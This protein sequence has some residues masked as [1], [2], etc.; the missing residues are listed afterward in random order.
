MLVHVDLVE[1][2]YNQKPK[3]KAATRQ[4]DQIIPFQ[5]G[6][7]WDKIREAGGDVS[8]DK[9]MN[10]RPRPAEDKHKPKKAP[11]V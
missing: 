5:A 9:G 7:T 10:S 6:R 2:G 4:A 3:G 8:P 11:A 1:V